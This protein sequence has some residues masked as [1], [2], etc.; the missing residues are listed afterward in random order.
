MSE[1]YTYWILQ[2]VAMLL[3]AAV[4][5]KLEVTNIFGALVTVL[6]LGFVNATVWDA[7]LFF[8][9]PNSIS[10]HSL[11]L[12]LSN[13]VVFWILVKLVPGIEVSGFLMALVAPVV[14]TLFSLLI[15]QHAADLDWGRMISN[16]LRQLELFRDS[17]ITGK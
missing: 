12:L 3:T 15:H 17:L 10:A 16:G 1:Y 14:F 11:T 5:P 13:G 7:A 9:I 6:L 2:T 4:L 8:Q